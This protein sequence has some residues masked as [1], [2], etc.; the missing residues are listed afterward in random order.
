MEIMRI[1][2]KIHEYVYMCVYAV[3]FL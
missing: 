3:K 2:E 1:H